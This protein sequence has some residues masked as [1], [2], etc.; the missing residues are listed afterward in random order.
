MYQDSTDE[1]QESDTISDFFTLTDNLWSKVDLATDGGPFGDNAYLPSVD[2]GDFCNMMEWGTIYYVPNGT[3]YVL[4]TCMV[5]FFNSASATATEGAYQI[6]ISEITWAGTAAFDI[7]TDKQLSAL[8][9]DTVAITAGAA[10]L[11]EVSNFIDINTFAEFEFES[12]KM[13]Y[14]SI[15]QQILTTPGLSDGTI[16]NGLYPYG[17]IINHDAGVY[18]PVSIGFPF[19]NP[20]II[21]MTPSA[22]APTVESYE[23]GWSGGADPSIVLKLRNTLTSSTQEET[24]ELTGVEVFP[25]PANDYFTVNVSIDNAEV[26]KYILTDVA[27]RVATMKF[28]NNVSND[29]QTFDISAY[30]AGVYFLTVIADGVKTT[31]RIIKK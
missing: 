21:E 15:Y 16:R 1:K 28:G 7:T 26:I 4:D 11:R 25:N 29:S 8:A 18:S 13:Y 30:P 14:I 20:L 5:R 19:Y 27:G 17:Q 31:K 10:I 23:V 12:G 22:G 9:S 3:N 6:R 24:V 2:A